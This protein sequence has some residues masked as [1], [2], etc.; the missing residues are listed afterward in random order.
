MFDEK[1]DAAVNFGAMG[2][3]IA[4]EMTHGYDDQGRK[5]DASG[6]YG[7]HTRTPISPASSFLV[8]NY[9]LSLSLSF[10]LSMVDWWTEED[11]KNFTER[12]KKIVEQFAEFEVQTLALSL[13]LSHTPI[14][15]GTQVYTQTEPLP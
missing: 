6:K 15:M 12:S 8:I 4:H 13:S 14:H 3:V 5:F 9:S 2:A 11:A 10:L 1:V 7:D